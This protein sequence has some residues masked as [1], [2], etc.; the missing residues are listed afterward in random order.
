[1]AKKRRPCARSRTGQIAV[2]S[3]FARCSSVPKLNWKYFSI[4]CPTSDLREEQP[5]CTIALSLIAR[6]WPPSSMA[7]S[8]S[9]SRPTN[10]GRLWKRSIHD[11]LYSF[12]KFQREM[13]CADMLTSAIVWRWM[14]RLSLEFTVDASS[15]AM[16]VPCGSRIGAPEHDSDTL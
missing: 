1:M 5:N 7:T 12:R 16:M 6:M 2:G 13:R 4:D 15:T 11:S 3:N 14:S 9:C 10:S 8:A